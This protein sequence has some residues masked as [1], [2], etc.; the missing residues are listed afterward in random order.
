MKNINSSLIK[1][2]LVTGALSLAVVTQSV[3][4]QPMMEER[5]G[6]KAMK[7]MAKRLGLSEEQKTQMKQIMQNAK[8][9]REKHKSEFQQYRNELKA[10]VQAEKFDQVAFENLNNSYQSLFKEKALAKAK[11]RHQ[12]YQLLNDEQKVKM[13]QMKES[14]QQRRQQAF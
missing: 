3:S 14:R 4:A 8:T 5:G 2:A 6:V 7:M 13:A 12:M 10:I 9:E 11:V 1:A